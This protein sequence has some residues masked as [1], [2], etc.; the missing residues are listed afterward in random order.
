MILQYMRASHRNWP[1]VLGGDPP[2][3]RKHCALWRGPS[4]DSV[5][6]TDAMAALL[7]LESSQILLRTAWPL[8]IERTAQVHSESGDLGIQLEHV[9]SAL[10]TT[11]TPNQKLVN[12]ASLSPAVRDRK[13]GQHLVLICTRYA[14]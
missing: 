7:H 10:S 3:Q 2:Y 6:L 12:V 5:W 11:S 8:D 13:S 14:F 4:S 1:S 9:Q